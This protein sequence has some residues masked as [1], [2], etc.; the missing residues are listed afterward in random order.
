MLPWQPTA[1]LNMLISKS[2]FRKFCLK[3]VFLKFT[4]IQ[5]YNITSIHMKYIKIHH[6]WFE[7]AFNSLYNQINRVNKSLPW[8]LAIFL[9]SPRCILD[10][11]F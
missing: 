4:E 6:K 7:E 8:D 10:F 11:K 5:E 2:N 3:M 9:N 1:I